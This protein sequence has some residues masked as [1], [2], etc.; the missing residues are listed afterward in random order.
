MLVCGPVGNV[1]ANSGSIVSSTEPQNGVE[2]IFVCLVTNRVLAEETDGTDVVVPIF[3]M[4][5]R[6]NLIGERVEGVS[7]ALD[8]LLL[9][10]DTASLLQKLPAH[11]LKLVIWLWE[12]NVMAGPRC[13]SFVEPA[14]R[15]NAA[16]CHAYAQLA[17]LFKKKDSAGTRGQSEFVDGLA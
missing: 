9:E 16:G 17:M 3:L 8:F 7:V 10:L 5:V 11:I 13:E 1:H 6:L 2:E 14:S 15:H 12:L 4:W